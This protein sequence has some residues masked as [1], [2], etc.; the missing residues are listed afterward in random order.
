MKLSQDALMVQY[1]DKN[2]EQAGAELC[3]SQVMLEAIVEVVVK[4]RS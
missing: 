2:I 3:Q 1:N 4:V